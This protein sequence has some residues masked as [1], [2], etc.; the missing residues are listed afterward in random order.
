MQNSF[1][2]RSLPDMP[3][4]V[5]LEL[6]LPLQLLL[7]SGL[8]FLMTGLLEAKTIG[9]VAEAVILIVMGK[10]LGQQDGTL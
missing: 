8:L 10:L 2:Q 6:L 1:K 7:A 4:E 3:L 9:P 5:P